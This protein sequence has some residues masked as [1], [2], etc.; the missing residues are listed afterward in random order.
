MRLRSLKILAISFISLIAAYLL[1]GWLAL[2]RII[3]SQAPKYIAE[4]TGHRLSFDLPE[5]DPLRLNLHLA[6][7]RLL[8]PNG[9]PLLAFRDLRINLSAS[10][11]YRRSYIFNAIQID[12]PEVSFVLQSNGQL[13]W[14]PLL[15]ALKDKDK[16]PDSPLPPFNIQNFSLNHGKLNFDD[17]KAGFN[18]QLEP[19][20]L[21]LKNIST[22]QNGE[23]S[24]KIAAQTTFGTHILWEGKT[25]LRPIASK[26]SLSIKNINL[27]RV[28]PYF[29]DLPATLRSGTAELSTQYA[30]DYAKDRFN[31]SLNHIAAH[32][33]HLNVDIKEGLGF[34]VNLVQFLNGH[35][36]LASQHLALGALNFSGNVVHKPKLDGS[37]MQLLQ[38]G[39][40]SLENIQVNLA[41]RNLNLDHIL[42]KDGSLKAVRNKHGHIDLL[43]PLK[44]VPS[45]SKAVTK[46]AAESTRVTTSNNPWR[47]HVKT[48]ELKN[49]FASLHDETVV[50][51]ADHSL[52]DIALSVENISNDLSIQL[53]ARASLN[54]KEGGSFEA[55]G[56]FL[57]SDASA[58]F[59]IKL[60][61]LALVPLTPYLTS[62]S[63][64]SVASGILNTEGAATFSN[65]GFG[66]K[67]GF[68]L[69]QVRLIEKDTHQTFLVWNSLNTKNMR[70][71]PAKLDIGDLSID[72]SSSRLIINKDKSVNI[73]HILRTPEHANPQK[74]T[75]KAMPTAA[76][77]RKSSP[78]FLVNV[79]R[80]KFKNSQMD[81]ADYSLV[82]PFATRIHHLHG[83]IDGLS[84]S[85]R[86]PGRVALKGNV[87][88]YGLAQATGQINFLNPTDFTDINVAFRNVEMTRLTPY[89]ST[90][91]GRK[92]KS[93]KLSLNL[94]YKFN[95]RQLSGKNQIT[96]DK[97]TLGEHVESPEA[98]NLP[99]DLAIA[100]LEDSN[101][102]I[103]QSLTVSGSLDNPQFS[104]REIIWKAI[105][106][107]IEK[108]ATA[109]FRALGSLFSHGEKFENI[110]F[111]AGNDQLLPP[112]QEKL[113]QLAEALS[114]RRG[115]VM[116]V[117][118]V[119]ADSDKTALQDVQLRR[120]IAKQTG[121]SMDAE[122]D[123][124]PLAT[125]SPKVQTALEKL[126]ATRLGRG[127]LVALKE[128][129]RTANPGQLT[130]NVASKVA[131]Q[132][133][134]LFHSKRSLSQNEIEQLKGTDFYIILFRR[135]QETETVTETQLQAMAKKR[136]E[137]IV[138][139]F[140]TKGLPNER[141]AIGS[142]EKVDSDKQGNL[143]V[144]LVLGAT[145]K[146]SGTA[147]MP[148]VLEKSGN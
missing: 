118:G 102:R 17:K 115:L 85:P 60:A 111:E 2:P 101:G 5:F 36:D 50:P 105:I 61:K 116:T 142:I 65:K 12:K 78:A 10:S 46:P 94:E 83:A 3:H 86:A 143:S 125:H 124:G 127:E 31:L 34:T 112:E 90:F 40:L 64:L 76:A 148:A 58:E 16:K 38:L 47:Y 66:F 114:K 18:T 126:F 91:A 107:V 21:T 62:V 63:R 113:V 120:V 100:M 99:L 109:P 11:L 123:P 122:D 72:G 56:K 45:A 103:D 77:E 70:M 39:A 20:E 26:G 54:M 139:F 130:E 57:P 132:L 30:I 67:G 98:K 73:S 52:S 28:A 134:G 25:T 74:E 4:K 81:F 137:N 7:L 104:F 35:Y 8:E 131:S 48:L 71:T 117:H 42:L 138:L 106:N 53:P 133:S 119:Y 15:E 97:L 93:G 135:L 121:Q 110:T 33:V 129:F 88:D 32:I 49:F 87:D 75:P 89:S 68:D 29:K 140:K 43:E 19:L 59:Q 146:S 128:G 136:S 145:P 13:N 22:L 141:V 82:F 24:Y 9:R 108:I 144:K 96:M 147:L 92:I 14:T 55:T 23:G 6:N 27:L 84:S 1:F 51:A 80:F 41:D 37:A 79:D 44:T 69:R 95:K